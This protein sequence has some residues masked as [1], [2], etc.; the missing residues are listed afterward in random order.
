M[1]KEFGSKM[2]ELQKLKET[3]PAVKD[4][5]CEEQIKD[6][7]RLFE[8]IDDL[9]E[10]AINSQTSPMAYQ[11]LKQTKAEFIEEFLETALKYRLPEY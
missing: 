10:S 8:M 9:V 6:I 5:F 7:N 11:Q 1:I 4:K 2:L 3:R